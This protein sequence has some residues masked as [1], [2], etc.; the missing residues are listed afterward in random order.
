MFYKKRKNTRESFLRNESDSTGLD[1]NN[2]SLRKADSLRQNCDTFLSGD[3]GRRKEKKMS[4]QNSAHARIRQYS[5]PQLSTGKD[6]YIVYNAYD[7]AA[8]R[9]RRKR[10]RVTPKIKKT[11]ER[12][13]YAQDVMQ[14]LTEQ[15]R[16]G[17][18]PWITY[19]AS[20]AYT[21]WTEACDNYRSTLGRL[22][23]DGCLKE[24]T[25]YGYLRM[26]DTFNDW[27]SDQQLRYTFQFDR[28]LLS[29]FIDWIW[30]DRGLSI[31]TRNNYVTW[32]KIFSRWLQSKEY[33]EADAADGLQLFGGK[34]QSGK[35]RTIIPAEAMERLRTY[36]Q[37]QNTH[38]LLACYVLYYC[39]I[40]P[41][42]MSYIQLKHISVERGT[43]YI[44]DYSAKNG[45]GATVTLP[46]QVIRLMI[47]LRIFEHPDHYYL[48]SARCRPG[49]ERHTAK[50]FS[51]FWD[52]HIRRDLKFPMEW[53][54]YSLK[55]TGITDLIKDNTDLL[56]VR[57]QA[58]HHSLL[59][60]DIYTPH[61]IEAANDVIRHRSGRF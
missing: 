37:D 51:D 1:I 44:P 59:M 5:L 9:M 22:K 17:W 48:F 26:L 42:E 7:P 52:H 41:N 19:Q 16:S 39:L 32:L 28:R 4:Y 23:A 24:K 58:R 11:S 60:T 12:R 49:K 8:G 29:R 33:I 50:Q 56:S 43:I 15:L 40:R 18:N 10:M 3:S 47:Q 6:W 20:E 14:R 38:F 61:D 2:L 25:I 53:K 46:D 54:F 13:Q 57:N 21:S 30:L 27:A 35:N 36:C 45:K 34:A 55:D 31:R